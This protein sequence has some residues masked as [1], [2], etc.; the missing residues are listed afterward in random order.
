MRM[1]D[2]QLFVVNQA[3]ESS[4]DL[5]KLTT[6]NVRLREMLM[7]NM[8][9][10]L[11]KEEASLDNPFLVAAR[12]MMEKGERMYRKALQ[13]YEDV[14]MSRECLEQ[15]LDRV[16]ILQKKLAIREADA[17]KKVD[18]RDK[19]YEEA[20]ALEKRLKALSALSDKQAR[21]NKELAA[22][23]AK[24]ERDLAKASKSSSRDSN[25][26]AA[27]P[28]DVALERERDALAARAEIAEQTVADLRADRAA[29][30]ERA[31][32]AEAALK[33]V[34]AAEAERVR[35]ESATDQA[36]LLENV[37][38]WEAAVEAYRSK[39]G[40]A[41]IALSRVQPDRFADY[42]AK[43]AFLRIRMD[44]LCGGN[45]VKDHVLHDSRLDASDRRA[46]V[47]IHEALCSALHQTV[48]RVIGLKE[49]EKLVYALLA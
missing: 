21:E 35:K 1:S 48:P 49:A 6:E 37:A 26:K 23:C 44:E 5:V 17:K 32:A 28:K 31:E 2:T 20:A 30:V 42:R 7:N 3:P 36:T 25:P 45:P 46:L 19:A 40:S 10:L 12:A 16:E 41:K 11:D 18:Q 34:D 39:I 27:S 47:D 4:D 22:K 14:K 38:E 9:G 8:R 13:E 24:L 15:N 33:A 29:L 43:C